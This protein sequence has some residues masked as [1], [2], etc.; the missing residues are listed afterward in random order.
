MPVG[1]VSQL[2]AFTIPPAGAG[3][4]V[5][6][7]KSNASRFRASACAS[8]SPGR[9]G[10]DGFT[11]ASAA[12]RRAARPPVIDECRPYAATKFTSDSRCFR[13]NSKSRQL[14]YG[15]IAELLD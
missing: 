4:R 3:V 14:E 1:V 8:V 13:L 7:M 11:S 6:F 2:V 12:A 15:F 5:A 9:A 10:T